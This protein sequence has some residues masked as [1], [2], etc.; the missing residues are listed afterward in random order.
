MKQAIQLVTFDLGA[1]SGRAILGSFD[2]D[3]LTLEEVYRFPNGPVN[4]LGNLHWDVLRLFSEIKQGLALCAQRSGGRLAAI[5]LDTW[6]VDFA[7]LDRNDSLLGNPYHYRDRRT[8]GMMEEA[9]RLIPRQEIFAETGIQFMQI[10]SL[11]QLFSMVVHRSPLLE[12]AETFLMMPDLFNFWLTGR[13]VCEFT[14]A[15]TTQ[16]YNPRSGGWSRPIFEKLGLPSHIM[17]EV[18]PPG[19]VLGPLMPVVAEEAGMKKQ[20]EVIAPACHD[21]GAAVAAVPAEGGNFAYIS[22]GTW[23]IPGVELTEPLITEQSLEYNFTNEGGVNGTF[24]FLKNVM[25]LWLVQE[26]K[27]VWERGGEELSY[28]QLIE[29][30]AAA[31]PL[32]SLLDPDYSGFLSPGD[33]PGRIQ[34]Y[35]RQ[36]GQVVPEEKGAIVRCALESLALKY[37]LTIEKMEEILGYRLETI[38]IVGGGTRNK[39]LCQFTADATGRPVTGGPVEATAAG[40]LIMQALAL[41]HVSSLAEGRALI[42]RSF[43]L[44]SYEPRG[45]QLWDEACPRFL[46]LLELRNPPESG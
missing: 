30:A 10:N 8:D 5:G 42:R 18:V 9:F 38:H 22:S 15:T 13:K 27:R 31:K 28:D 24:R 29:M 21:T 7:L 46:R 1:E 45:R 11:F 3:R 44:D 41:G 4:I 26:C 40:N 2:G 39:L 37:R 16:F 32:V 23:C 34:D 12:V 35:C 20:V 25:G 36:T 6:G 33:M 14:D 43:P 19:T 17:P